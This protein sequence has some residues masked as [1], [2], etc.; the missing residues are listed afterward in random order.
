MPL[1]SRPS[2]SPGKVDWGK[3]RGSVRHI[4]VD[5]SGLYAAYVLEQPPRKVTLKMKG[6]RL[7]T[8]WS[9]DVFL[10]WCYFVIRVRWDTRVSFDAPGYM[11]FSKQRL[12]HVDKDHLGAVVFPNVFLD[13][14]ICLGYIGSLRDRSH[15]RVAWKAVRRMYSYVGNQWMMPTRPEFYTKEIQEEC[16][17]GHHV[18]SFNGRQDFLCSMSLLTQEEMLR[19]NWRSTCL[20]IE[21]AATLCLASGDYQG[22]RLW[23]DASVEDELSKVARRTTA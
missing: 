12:E 18:H 9:H 3:P 16:A 5:P 21:S 14:R 4:Q 7:P 1:I 23:N 20:T 6:S 15:V 19:I 8:G 10:P 2:E 11:Y 13:G 22:I 17:R